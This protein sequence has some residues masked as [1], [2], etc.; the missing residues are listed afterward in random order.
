YRESPGKEP[1]VI[2]SLFD[3]Y[4]AGPTRALQQELPWALSALHDNGGVL[5]L[6]KRWAIVIKKET[7]N[8]P[9]NVEPFGGAET[10]IVGVYRDP[11]GTG[12]GARIIA[13]MYGFCTGYPGYDGDLRPRL[14][15]RRLL[16]GVRAGVES[17]GNKSGVPTVYGQTFFDDGY[18]GKPAIF[19]AAI[20][21]LP[22]EVNGKPGY[23]NEVRQGDRIVMAGGRVGIDGIHGATQSSLEGGEGVT[24]DHVQIGN[25]FTQKKL[26]DFLEEAR[27]RGLY[28]CIT[29]NGAGG[30]SSSVGEMARK[31]GGFAMDLAKVPL[32]Y[33]GLHP[34]QILISE[35][36][37]RMTL[38]VDPAD[39][40]ALQEL[41]QVHDVEISNLG[42]FSRSGRFTAT[43][44]DKPVAGLDMEFL[45]HGTPRL[46]LQAEWLPP[47][48]R[49]LREPD[50][51]E[52]GDYA[53]LLHAL[54]RD[55]N[56]ASKEYIARQFDHEVQGTSVIKPLVG[57]RGDVFSDA[58]VIRPVFEDPEGVALAAAVNPWYG[59]IDTYAM[60]ALGMDEA[61]R[62]VVAVGAD[63]ERI[64][65]MDNFCWPS[66]LPG[67]DNPD[68]AY[69]MAQLVRAN[70]ALRE[71]AL[72]F[73]TP[74]MSGKDSMSMD[75][76]LVGRDGRKHRMSALPTLDI[77]AVGVVPD[78]RGCVTMDVKR[79]GDAV[80]VLG[81][82]R[83]ELG[84]S[85][86][87]RHHGETGLSVP[88]V[89]AGQS[90]AVVR[91]LH[92]AMQERLVRS[93]AGCYRG[94]LGLAATF[95]SLGG[96]YG[97]AV[98]LS[99]VPCAGSYRPD[100]L[101]FS[102]SAGRYLVAV[103][104]AAKD[105][106]ERAVRGVPL[107][108]VGEVRKD[109]YLSFRDGHGF[110]TGAPLASLRSAWQAPFGRQP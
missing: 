49:G 100:R 81:I 75:G 44:G 60:A 56:V 61:I 40:P 13:G 45:H 103:P 66:P 87:Y 64:A 43:Y 99:A 11:M 35:S 110:S 5:R 15:P 71:Y 39:Y 38:A 25:P 105:A 80:Y 46:A 50:L 101:L 22:M 77:T 27:D 54:L 10:G 23:V 93:A 4:I 12:M 2:A 76:P 47:E 6:N 30:L 90:K 28:R 20:G 37:E 8:S 104:S 72:A 59:I 94:G 109:D 102:E 24:A 95:A 107:G 3:T 69:K 41:A 34:W 70:Q 67:P 97:V 108:L 36:Q 17:G 89:D 42:A 29:D 91:A 58:A 31:A 1:Q 51:A 65:L 18:M 26:A 14:H 19:V 98:D 7:H 48:Q 55:P 53:A 73:R 85:L 84:G 63:P 96:G 74:F 79:P 83:D 68:A 86:Y 21:L 82:T 62:R 52:P 78:V 88:A 57:V 92:Q 106:F 33:R 9:S 16:E 32:K